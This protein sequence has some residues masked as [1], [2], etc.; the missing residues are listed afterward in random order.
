[1][2]QAAPK[3]KRTDDG[4]RLPFSRLGL[5]TLALTGLAALGLLAGC[6][7]SGGSPAVANVA[8]TT[9]PAT[10]VAS[11]TTTTAARRESASETGGSP[12]GGAPI[13]PRSGGN[14]VAMMVGNAA[15]GTRFA[16]C[17]R[18][19]G[20]PNFPDPDP[21]GNLQFGSEINPH[22]P[23]FRSALNTCR[24][25]LP[26]GFGQAPTAAQLAQVQQQLLAFATCMRTRGIEDFPDPTG[27]ELPPIQPVGDLDP[28]DPQFQTA[29][30]ACK[31]HIPAGVPAKALG[32][33]AP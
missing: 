7:S 27:G 30:N 9:T 26:A 2:T 13:S 23:I 8:S 21:Q 24:K 10:N 31:T 4:T 20:V 11:T 3:S 1:M 28:N 33:L 14:H 17:M 5:P 6:G 12:V 15:Q 25:L 19:H 16:A 22:S 32:G 18:G 29:Y